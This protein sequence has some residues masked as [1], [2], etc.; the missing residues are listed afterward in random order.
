MKK[1]IIPTE[2]VNIIEETEIVRKHEQKAKRAIK[3]QKVDELVAQGIDKE[4]AKAMTEAFMAC[5][6]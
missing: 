5:G 1:V 6:L 4:I 2:L 3:K